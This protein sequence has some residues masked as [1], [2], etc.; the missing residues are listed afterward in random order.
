[1][2]AELWLEKRCVHGFIGC[3]EM[4]CDHQPGEHT[5]DGY[6]TCSARW[7]PGGSRVR[8]DPDRAVTIRDAYFE[9]GEWSLPVAAIID[10]LTEQ[11][12]DQ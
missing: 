3:G 2:T 4:I 12:T 6:L 1:M 7:C 10:A 11:E 8:L 9:R 5:K